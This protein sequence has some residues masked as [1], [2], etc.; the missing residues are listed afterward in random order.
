MEEN[1]AMEGLDS[2]GQPPGLGGKEWMQGGLGGCKW[3][4]PQTWKAL[5]LCNNWSKLTKKIL[6][7]RGHSKEPAWPEL[8]PFQPE[9]RAQPC[10]VRPTEEFRV[11]KSKIV[12]NPESSFLDLLFISNCKCTIQITP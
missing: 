12:G 2:S 1:T 10:H 11:H 6:V 9:G 7:T 8:G 5:A 4:R 3:L